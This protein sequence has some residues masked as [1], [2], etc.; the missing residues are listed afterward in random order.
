VSSP[1]PALSA[2][3]EAQL[4]AVR[5]LLDRGVTDE[6]TA[7]A[8]LW[9]WYPTACPD[10]IALVVKHWLDATDPVE[11]E[12]EVSVVVTRLDGTVRLPAVTERETER[13]TERV[14]EGGP[15]TELPA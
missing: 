12:P 8:Q 11:A 13:E 10:Q 3:S 9:R 2:P 6:A 15:T 4:I 7:H 14:A 5:R 1:L